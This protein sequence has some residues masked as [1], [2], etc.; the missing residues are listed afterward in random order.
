MKTRRDVYDYMCSD[1]AYADLFVYDASTNGYLYEVVVQILHLHKTLPN[2]FHYDTLYKGYEKNHVVV[3]YV[4]DILDQKVQQGNDASDITWEKNSVMNCTSVKLKEHFETDEKGIANISHHKN[5][6]FSYVCK[7]KTILEDKIKRCHH[8]DTRLTP[9]IFRDMIDKDLTLDEQDI[10]AAYQNFQKSHPTLEEVQEHYIRN[11]RKPLQLRLHQQMVTNKF[12]NN[13]KEKLHLLAHVPRS[14]KSITIMKIALEAIKNLDI[15]RIL[16]V[17]P[18]IATIASFYDTVRD[19]TDFASLGDIYLMRDEKKPPPPNW[20]G[21]AI[22]SIQYFKTGNSKEDA[23]IDFDM[24]ISD[25]AHIGSTTELSKKVLFN[26]KRKNLRYLI[27]ASGTPCNTAQEYKIKLH[28]QYYWTDIDNHLMKDIVSNRAYLECNHGPEFSKVLENQISSTDYSHVPGHVYMKNNFDDT[29]LKKWNQT[30]PEHQ[31]GF[32]WQSILALKDPKSADSG[33]VVNGTSDGVEFLKDML[34]T[35]F[36][37][38]RMDMSAYKRA[39]EIRLRHNSRNFCN[40]ND[41]ELVLLFLPTHTSEG[42]I[43][44]LQKAL[45][46]FVKKHNLWKKFHVVFEN[47]STSIC[48]ENER[49]KAIEQGKNKMI[50]LLGDKNTTGVTY[51]NCDL[52]IHLDNTHSISHH[53]QKVARAATDAPGKSIYITI[54]MNIQRNFH[55]IYSMVK[56]AQ[57]TLRFEYP[58]DAVEWLWNSNTFMIDHD[59]NSM[60]IKE[61][62]RALMKELRQSQNDTL[63]LLE[64]LETDDTLAM[65]QAKYS[66]VNYIDKTDK[67]LEGDN[68]DVDK[69]ERDTHKNKSETISSLSDEDIELV[70]KTLELAKKIIPINGIF[71]LREKTRNALCNSHIF[72]TEFM[73]ILMNLDNGIKMCHYSILMDTIQQIR[74]QNI[75]IVERIEEIFMDGNFNAIRQAVSKYF[76]PTIDER[77]GA[78]EIPTPPQLVDTMLSVVPSNFWTVPQRV[79]EP[80]CGKGNFVLGIF[81]KFNEGLK[82]QYPDSYL[83]HKVIVEECIHFTDIS[84]LNVMITRELLRCASSGVATF[85]NSYQGD[86]LMMKWNDPF[87]L[88]AGNPP[89]NL[90][91]GNLKEGGPARPLYHTFTMNM[92]KITRLLLFVTPAR[93]MAGGLGMDGFRKSMLSSRKIITLDVIAQAEADRIFGRAVEIKGGVSYFLIDNNYTGNCMFNGVSTDISK[94]SIL[95]DSKYSKFIDM[96]SHLK[97]MKSI[98]KS[99]GSIWGIKSNDS[100][101]VKEPDDNRYVPCMVNRKSGLVKYCSPDIPKKYQKKWKVVM[102]EAYNS[103]TN[104]G[105]MYIASPDYVCSQSYLMIEFDTRDQALSCLSYLDTYFCRF[106]LSARK[107]SQHSKPDTFLWIPLISFD[108]IYTD[109]DI[110]AMFSIDEDMIKVIEDSIKK[111]AIYTSVKIP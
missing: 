24:V 52:S 59:D 66:S 92:L 93:W 21:V 56:N 29:P 76:I 26:T 90:M 49:R 50:L 105:N 96:I 15:K 85:Y 64:M 9:A 62:Y 54:D 89:Y 99:C 32:S 70:N 34:N 82:Q 48:L 6:Q 109:S 17:T 91:F 108:T 78:A 13:K 28:C 33:F 101:L 1:G 72:K 57:K 16:I 98:V 25:E 97:N 31:L 22:C 3:R 51:H 75:D 10:K 47:A 14:G 102:P 20:T 88:I 55:Y 60:N 37:D 104:F 65:L 7:D 74:K 43:D 83:R 40:P 68:Q 41:F 61:L 81:Q 79:L 2:Q 100:R 107:I 39:E 12:M 5:V 27:F 58:E 30:H 67:D 4:N 106:M 44:P 111:T 36:N 63:R 84:A 19:Y 45:L 87:D 71:C 23:S 80:C 95:V 11:K 38:R 73:P 8:S 86:T 18:I 53:K 69:G 42:N 46:A 35:L 103:G 110:Y 94:H 77:K